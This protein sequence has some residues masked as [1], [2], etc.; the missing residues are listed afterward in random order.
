MSHPLLTPLGKLWHA[1]Y[2]GL[3]TTSTNDGLSSIFSMA[4]KKTKQVVA[5]SLIS[6][7]RNESFIC[8]FASLFML[9]DAKALRQRHAHLHLDNFRGIPTWLLFMSIRSN[10][11]RT[12]ELDHNVVHQC[13]LFF[14]ITIE[15][16]AVSGSRFSSVLIPTHGVW[17]N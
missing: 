9:N 16:H 12:A 17:L 3:R 14:K 2:F 10:S 6:L 5:I 4:G 1:F 8:A 13:H 11:K 7:C 15:T